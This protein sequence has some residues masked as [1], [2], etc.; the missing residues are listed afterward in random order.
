MKNETEN[1]FI[2]SRV[3]SEGMTIKNGILNFNKMADFQ[4]ELKKIKDMNNE[5]LDSYNNETNFISLYKQY[6]LMDINAENNI[7]ESASEAQE[8]LKIA[9]IQDDYFASLVNKDGLIICENIIYK[10]SGAYIQF[11]TL[12]P[13]ENTNDI[14]WNDVPQNPLSTYNYGNQYYASF[15]PN[16]HFFDKDNLGV[17]WAKSNNKTVRATHTVWCSNW[18]LYSGLGSKVKMERH[19]FFGWINISHTNATN[20]LNSP[21]RQYGQYIPT[22]WI[23]S[24]TSGTTTTGGLNVNQV[25][26]ATSYGTGF[27]LQHRVGA[28]VSNVSISR[29]GQTLSTSWTN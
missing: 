4:I 1:K 7:S 18:I 19:S 22:S 16:S 17:F 28:F 10:Y 21:I 9:N 12:A 26:R 29:N 23:Y 2:F 14:N 8:A 11:K 5:E 20:T 25:I 3:G 24:T 13:S 27:I 6:Q 15:T